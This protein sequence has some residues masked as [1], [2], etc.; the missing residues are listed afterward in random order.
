M[1]TASDFDIASFDLPLAWSAKVED[2][3]ALNALHQSEPV[4]VRGLWH[5]LSRDARLA[6]APMV[7]R[8]GSGATRLNA[9]VPIVGND[10]TT[11]SVL[12]R[13]QTYK[14]DG[15][16][17]IR[18]ICSD[19]SPELRPTTAAIQAAD[20]RADT[21]VLELNHRVRNI[22]SVVTAL[23]TLSSRF[24][25][26]VDEFA[27]STLGRIQALNIAYSNTGIDP[28]NPHLLRQTIEMQ[29]LAAGV[30][31][32]FR[33][34]GHRLTICD[35]PMLLSGGQASAL[36]L[37]LHELATNAVRYGALSGADGSVGLSWKKKGREFEVTWT[38]DGGHLPD[39]KFSD[40]FG[41]TIIKL[42]A[43]NYLNGGAR[44]EQNGDRLTVVITGLE[45]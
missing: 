36:G 1:A 6:V 19:I 30:L 37:I 25:K 33:A 16:R 38:E 31:A 14:R 18:G 5:R 42:F 44:W 15:E 9:V 10:G 17:R 8:L 2:P 40:G 11:R 39:Q 4:S 23:I 7:R 3:F 41:L 13:A 34:E 26:D 35:E 20:H 43:R 29:N 24:A 45:N 22:M 12:V 28:A 21:A 27:A 32:R